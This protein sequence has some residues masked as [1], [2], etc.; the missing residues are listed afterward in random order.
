MRFRT[1]AYALVACIALAACGTNP[2]DRAVTGGGMG[3]ATGVV[4]GA[5]AGGP[6][7]GAAL[8]GGAAGAVAG[9][10]TSPNAVNFGKPFWQQ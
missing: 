7:V 9:A 6:I 8:L 1:L 10:V 3:A 4:I 5:I 2:G